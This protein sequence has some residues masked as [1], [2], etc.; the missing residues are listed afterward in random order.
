MPPSLP[1]FEE[2]SDFD[3]EDLA[4]KLHE[5]ADRDIYIGCSS[6]KYEGWLGQVYTPE[7]YLVRGRF[8]RRKFEQECIAEYAE[9][10][11]I[12][13]GDFSFYQ[14][15]P[16]EFWKKLFDLAP[17]RL[18]FAFK[19]P[20]EIT[21]KVFPTH[22]RYGDRAGRPNPTFLSAEM[23][24]ASFL[25]PL[26]PYRERIAVLIVEFGT[27]SKKSYPEPAQ[28]FAELDDF[29]RRLPRDFRWSVEVRNHEY[30]QPA[31]FEVLR[32]HAVAHVCNAWTRM[33]PL[34]VQIRMPETFTAN[35]VVARALLRAGRTYEEAVRRFQP[36]DR[37]QDEH[38]KTR[39]ALR[40]LIGRA[41]TRREPAYLFVNNRLEGNAPVTIQAVV[42]EQE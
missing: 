20:E 36:Y 10:F 6:W 7:R 40:Q 9:T 37:V 32:R 8:S 31:Y 16:P 2:P 11:P 39:D 26:R 25:E 19:T 35:Y 12:V 18:R 5:L 15:P 21:A 13:C 42:E 30:L 23:L 27:F 3:R 33:P 38:P 41:R 34:A 1:L 4:G 22:P 14:F 17:P 28:F 29:L 24:D